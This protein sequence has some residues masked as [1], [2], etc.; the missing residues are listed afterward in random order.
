M[1]SKWEYIE[2]MGVKY[3][4]Y[5]Y[6]HHHHHHLLYPVMF[7]N[8]VKPSTYWHAELVLLMK[9]LVKFTLLAQIA[10]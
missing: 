6:Y 2:P 10:Y 1:Y 9:N 8:N 5:Y 7:K 3:Y 4:Y